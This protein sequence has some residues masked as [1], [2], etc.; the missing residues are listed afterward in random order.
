ME[1]VTFIKKLS[2]Y[3]YFQNIK[4]VLIV[5]AFYGCFPKNDQE[6][7]LS[8]I[9]HD[10]GELTIRYSEAWS[11]GPNEV[12]FYY[13]Q[14]DEVKGELINSTWVYNDGGRLSEH[15]LKVTLKTK[16]KIHFTLLGAEQEPEK[17]K[18]NYMNQSVVLKNDTVQ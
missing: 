12:F 4:Y 10:K 15:N 16:D 11:Y 8:K 2:M 9:K 18:L 14:Q 5:F 13:K 1:D 3:H 6:Y 7:T 17:W